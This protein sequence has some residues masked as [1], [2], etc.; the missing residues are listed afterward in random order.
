MVNFSPSQPAY[1]AVWAQIDWYSG[2]LSAHEM[3]R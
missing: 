3:G 2:G 1:V